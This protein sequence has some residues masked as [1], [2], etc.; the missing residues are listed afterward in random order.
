MKRW[1]VLRQYQ[2]KLKK[3]VSELAAELPA[4][5]MR[6]LRL[7]IAAFCSPENLDCPEILKVFGRPE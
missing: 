2:P 4:A 1:E 3:L 5:D 6:R 7:G